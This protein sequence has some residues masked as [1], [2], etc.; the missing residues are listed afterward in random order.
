MPLIWLGIMILTIILEAVTVGLIFIWFIP[1]EIVAMILAFFDIGF[2]WQFGVFIVI[3]IMIFP[4]GI[5]ISKGMFKKSKTNIEAL[6][7]RTAIITEEVNN[8]AALG[9]AKLEGKIW[10]A[11]S[12]RDEI[13]LDI[14]EYVEVVDIQGVKLI[15]KKK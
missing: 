15:C 3:S 4:L 7:G 5:K 10:S 11:R 12:E 2:L 9:A 1:G 13:I 6:I 8:V 14:G